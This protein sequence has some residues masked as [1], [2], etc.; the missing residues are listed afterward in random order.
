MLRTFANSDSLDRKLLQACELIAE[1][2]A[3]FKE[4]ADRWLA[5]VGYASEES[6]GTS[7]SGHFSVPIPMCRNESWPVVREAMVVM[8]H[9]MSWPL[10]EM[11]H[12]HWR[13]VQKLIEL[14]SQTTHPKRL[15]LPGSIVVKCRRGML[16]IERLDTPH[17][18]SIAP[19]RKY[20]HGGH[21]ER[22]DMQE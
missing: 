9:R 15:D 6:L 12:K 3:V 8:W 1:E 4:L 22:D 13:R 10:R 2:H 5:K 16:R 20:N 21:L 7:Q 19:P 11:N 14:A 17:D 18:H